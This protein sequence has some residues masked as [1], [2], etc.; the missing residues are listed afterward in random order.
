MAYIYDQE[1]Q[2]MKEA[3][4]QILREGLIREAR[5]KFDIPIPQDIQQIQDIFK[6]NGFKLYV[7]G[8]AVRDA[9]LGK[10]PKDYDLATDAVP[11]KVEEMMK[12]AGLRTLPTGKAFG[13]INVFTSEGEYE[14]ATFR[15][16]LSGGRRP[17]GVSFTDIEGD[18]KRRDLTINALFYDI[19]THEIVDLVGGV[20]D[21]R[22][23]IVRT[24]GAPEDR[25]GEDR[26]RI[27][28]A[29]RFAGRFGNELDP[30][31][32]AALQ[33]DASLQGISGERIRDEFIKGLTSAKSQKHFLQMLDKYHLFDWIFRG[34]NVDKELIGKLGGN[35]ED[36]IVLLARLLKGNS[37]DVLKKKLNELKYTIDEIKGISFLIAMLKLSPDTA[38]TLKRAE[39]HSGIT[40]EQ[41]R[42]FCKKEAVDSKLIDAFQKFRLTVSGAEVMDHLQIKQ[43]PELGKAIQKIETDN[44]KK[45]LTLN[46]GFLDSFKKKSGPEILTITPNT[47][48]HT[49][50]SKELINHL[51][52]GG[53]YIGEKEN[54]ND[55]N[56]PK[57]GSFASFVNANAP[58]FKKGGLFAGFELNPY[59]ITTELPDS[60]FQPNRNA[61]NY[62]TLQ[63]SDNVGVLKPEYRKSLNFK[64]WQRTKDGKYTLI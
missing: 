26:L 50:S 1:T 17:D 55:F 43:G 10:T 58:N 37:I 8:G 6:K 7:V 36:Y 45:L 33:K 16:D 44:F 56:V 57:K 61:K 30:A 52:N 59:Y 51:K 28:R 54:L 38:V 20:E 41:S 13:V 32:D 40:P 23:G 14:I 47:W 9:L 49:T 19:D 48:V 5:I 21:L 63:Q 39:Q 18:V 64:L 35:S 29:I 15:E 62:D 46:E 2:I 24:V 53:D 60:A 42:E 34:L 3:I 31:T 25:F 11:D 12:K 22:N 27:M 4:K